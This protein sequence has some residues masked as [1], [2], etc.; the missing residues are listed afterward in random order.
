VLRPWDPEFVRLE[1]MEWDF[2]Q[3]GPSNAGGASTYLLKVWHFLTFETVVRVDLNQ[4]SQPWKA[5]RNAPWVS[6]SN[7]V[8]LC[9]GEELW[10]EF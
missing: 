4:H 2:G 3:I 9:V 10:G 5:N 6:L 8:N 1:T 7:Y